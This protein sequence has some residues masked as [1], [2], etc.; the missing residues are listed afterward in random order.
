[1]ELGYWKDRRMNPHAFVAMP[2]GVKRKEGRPGNAIDFNRVYV[3]LI[4]PTLEAVG[5]E[6][7]RADEGHRRRRR[8]LIR[9]PLQRT[10]RI[11]LR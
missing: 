1:M 2:F 9:R 5:L 3:E 4:R 11:G 6:V 10:T 8:R 7:F